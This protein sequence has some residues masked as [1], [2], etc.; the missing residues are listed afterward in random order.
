MKNQNNIKNGYPKNS[1]YWQNHKKL[2]VN[3]PSNLFDIS[4]GSILGDACMYKVSKNSKLK[5]EQGY[6]HKDYLFHLFE[7]FKLYTFHEE[8]YIRYELRGERKGIVKSYSFRTFTHPIFD[9]IWDLFISNGNKSIKPNLI[10][11]YLTAEGLTYWIIDD[12]SLQQNKLTLILHTQGYSK[13]EVQI[14]SLELN[15]KFNF[16]SKVIVHKK[17]YWVI[18]IPKEDAKILH[19]LI[20]PYIHNS[21]NYKLPKIY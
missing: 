15:K 6:M 9:P 10:I 7:F 12:G 20:K 14:L 16:H 21:I 13:E 17:K 5:F 4:I 3:L 19:N 8:P 11:N 1:T 18:E 2:F